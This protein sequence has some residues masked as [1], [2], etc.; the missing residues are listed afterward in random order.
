[1]PPCGGAQAIDP[2]QVITS[3]ASDTDHV[4]LKVNDSA[5]GDA[6]VEVT[7]SAGV[8]ATVAP[9]ADI[10]C[11][12]GD[13]AAESVAH[14]EASLCTTRDP[15]TVSGAQMKVNHCPDV[16]AASVTPSSCAAG[17]AASESVAPAQLGDMSAPATVAV[18]VSTDRGSLSFCCRVLRALD[19]WT[20]S[21]AAGEPVVF[22]LTLVPDD[23]A[24]IIQGALILVL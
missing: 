21:S 14:V 6:L 20:L 13:P 8:D 15:A 12:A 9:Q 18:V 23:V 24:S 7:C 1:M 3:F 16:A 22:D 10:N 2:Q 4:P 19:V 5:A 17:D 11:A